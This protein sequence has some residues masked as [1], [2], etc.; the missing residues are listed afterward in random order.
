MKHVL[1][2]L[3]LLTL[4]SLPAAAQDCYQDQSGGNCSDRNSHSRASS[5]WSASGGHSRARSSW[6]GRRESHD[7]ADS[8]R[9]RHSR[10]DSERDR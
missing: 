4:A 5:E 6:Q 10:A 7:R 8:D 1:T 2:A 3:A 9:N